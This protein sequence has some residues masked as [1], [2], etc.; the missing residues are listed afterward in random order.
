MTVTP[1]DTIEVHPIPRQHR[2]HEPPQIRPW[3]FQ[4][5]MNMVRHLA[6]QVDAHL[7]RLDRLP[8]PR[9]QVPPVEIAHE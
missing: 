8:K 3:G 9:Q 6:E 2:L 7:V 5:N 4:D 1:M